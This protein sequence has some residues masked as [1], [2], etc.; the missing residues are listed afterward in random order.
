MERKRN[1]FVVVK[2]SFAHARF[3]YRRIFNY[4]F[5]RN[6]F[7]KFHRALSRA[8]HELAAGALINFTYVRAR[9]NPDDRNHAI[10]SQIN[11]QL[12]RRRGINPIVPSTN[13]RHF[14]NALARPA[15][16]IRVHSSFTH[17]T[18]PRTFTVT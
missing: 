8:A 14:A 3:G 6:V 12:R 16:R 1:K 5:A 4:Y 15:I 9:E 18:S 13:F 10:R 11:S 2:L 7:F 17:A